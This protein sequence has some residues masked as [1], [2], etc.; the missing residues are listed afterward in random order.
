MNVI[1]YIQQEIF[2]RIFF[3]GAVG[4]A[5]TFRGLKFHRPIVRPYINTTCKQFGGFNICSTR[6]I[7]NIAKVSPTPPPKSPSIR[8][9]TYCQKCLESKI[10]KHI[11]SK[12][13]SSTII[14]IID[15]WGYKPQQCVHHTTW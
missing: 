7:I 2:V 3:V 12:L 10:E 9:I 4:I 6:L 14:H 13:D 11:I 5:Q 15:A 8:L 1:Q